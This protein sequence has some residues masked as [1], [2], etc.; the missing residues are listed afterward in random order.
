MTAFYSAI[1]HLTRHPRFSLF[2]VV[3]LASG[4]ITFFFII[5]FVND[6]L[7]YDKYNTHYNNIL[8]IESSLN[9]GGKNSEYATAPP[10][11]GANITG[12]FPDI[13]AACRVFPEKGNRF[14]HGN[15][16]IAEDKG[17][18]ADPSLFKVFTLPFIKGNER[19]ALQKPQS[20]VLSEEAAIKYFGTVDIVDKIITVQKDGERHT[21]Q[22]T[23]VMANIPHQSHFHFDF[24][25]SMA[26][27]PVSQNTN[28]LAFYP[29]STYVLTRDGTNKNI[30]TSKVNAWYHSSVPDYNEIE[31][32]G[33]QIQLE[34]TSLGDIH[35]T[36]NKKYELA[37]NSNIQYIYILSF[38]A[39]F[40]LCMAGINFM[41]LSLSR[42]SLRIKEVGIRKILGSSVRN[43]SLQFLLESFLL[44]F[45]S[46]LLAILFSAWLLKPFNNFAGT[47]VVL[48]DLVNV[49]LITMMVLA[50]IVA[51]LLSGFYPAV[52]FSS[53]RVAEVIRGRRS[54]SNGG[55]FLSLR[56]FLLIIQFVVSS[57]LIT[58]SVV[59]YKQL[60]FIFQKDNGYNR[61]E[62]LVIKNAATLSNPAILKN[63][64]DKLPG[65]V[66]STFSNYLPTNNVR[67]SNF[68]GT[69]T[70]SEPVE[71]EFWPVD[72]Q[73]IPTLGIKMIEG[74]NFSGSLYA[75]SSAIII[76]EAA[77]K[78]F[79]FVQSRLNKEISFSVWEGAKNFHVVGVVKD[80]HFNSLRQTITPLVFILNN[81][82]K[83][84]LVVKYR[85]SREAAFL[86]QI[87]DLWKSS[88][89]NEKMNV[90]YLDDDYNTIYK[91]DK[92]LSGLFMLFA[93]LSVLIA[94]L[95]LFGMVSYHI[96]AGKKE[97]AVRKLLGA[98][99]AS[100]GK[101]ISGPFFTLILVSV[102]IAL[103]VS[104]VLTI[105]WLESFAYRYHPSLTDYFFIISVP[106]L[107]A[108]LILLS[109]II[110]LAKGNLIENLRSN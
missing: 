78:H 55:S 5:I 66:S 30:L 91:D 89:A 35:L 44:C 4:F 1:R 19:V 60:N 12:R 87:E 50:A 61:A 40:I 53:S 56:R 83:A 37:N 107:F 75:D 41:N 38:G 2:N 90:S 18:Y 58:G 33:S 108:F 7:S 105:K 86:S 36:S 15:E 10:V 92:L 77:A 45:L 103:P 25:I 74:R 24:F 67:W 69:P 76:N 71:T 11:V 82:N 64:I 70:G 68:G 101:L 73:Y 95:G 16:L 51:G 49:R 26:S 27:L 31:K 21:Y 85:E 80:F 6:A 79:G 94:C 22:V 102:M 39:I 96:E 84:N 29:F 32:N 47:W 62:L 99:L 59:V 106:F 43:L 14:E 48:P 97:F 81:N 3:A 57:V 110:Q 63:K 23:G 98:S 65:V 52:V 28:F 34:L 13:I 100:L 8:R 104:W 20:I 72:D 17:A 88:G 42:F 9:L 46:M 54:V 109:K 93:I